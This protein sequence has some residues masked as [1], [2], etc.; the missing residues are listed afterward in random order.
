MLEV[1]PLPILSLLIAA[2]AI[3]APSHNGPQIMLTTSRQTLR[4]SCILNDECAA[5]FLL[6]SMEETM[7]IPCNKKHALSAFGIQHYI[8]M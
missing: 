7:T 8:N 1:V 5:R 2:H 3:R 4:Q 6:N